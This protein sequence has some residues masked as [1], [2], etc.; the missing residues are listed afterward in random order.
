MS[1]HELDAETFVRLEKLSRKAANDALQ[2]HG[3]HLSE[4]Q[5]DSLAMH[6]LGLG[7]RAYEAYDEALSGGVGRDTYAFR[8]M[9]GYRYG[10]FT[11]G[12][13]VDWLRTNIRDSRF[14]PEGSISLTEL[15]DLPER[16][17][18]HEHAPEE[19]AEHYAVGLSERDAWTLRHVAV[20][21]A[22]GHTM[23]Q[24]IETL[25]VDLADA[26]APQLL[27]ET[28]LLPT[29]ESFGDLIAD[30]LQEAV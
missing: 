7:V 22:G 12:P 19:V 17:S 4:D 18:E 26:L 8:A 15:G 5:F 28:S 24:V 9:R 20:A 27:P 10:S 1:V 30:W 16:M 3:G 14:E 29:L 25:L 6:V 23:Q 21:L 13:Y 11:D 2:A